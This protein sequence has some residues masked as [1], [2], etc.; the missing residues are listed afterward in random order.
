[1]KTLKAIG[2]YLREVFFPKPEDKLHKPKWREWV[3]AF[4]F[5]IIVA[6]FIRSFF[7]QT[8]KIDSGSMEKTLRVG[9]FLFI[10]RLNYCARLPFAS[11]PFWIWNR[12]KRG[13]IVVFFDVFSR[14]SFVKRC[15]GVPGDTIVIRNKIVYVNGKPL[16][17]SYTQ[18]IDPRVYPPLFDVMDIDTVT[19]Q[20]M[21][22]ERKFHDGRIAPFVRDNFGP[23]VV[24]P[25][26]FFMMGDNRD[27]SDDSR[28]WGPMPENN[29]IG[30]AGFIFFAIDPGVPFW[31]IW[32]KIRWN[33]IFRLVVR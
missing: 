32:K 15:I 11:K 29:L 30:R 18:F 22:V 26:S 8:Y 4:V 20:N 12:P 6:T 19:Y 7:I 23:V 13:E 31:Q 17:E 27:N 9:D 2:R 10:S 14:R 16:E 21:W 25:H 1:M 33:R 5:A 3:D 28:F 24:P